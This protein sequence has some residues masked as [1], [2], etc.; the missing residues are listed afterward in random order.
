MR[1]E[2][3]VTDSFNDLLLESWSNMLKIK[4]VWSSTSSL[5]DRKRVARI[6]VSRMSS[7]FRATPR[8]LFIFIF[9]AVFFDIVSGTNGGYIFSCSIWTAVVVVWS[10]LKA[11]GVFP[12]SGCPSH[13]GK[14]VLENL[15]TIALTNPKS[16]GLRSHP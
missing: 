11:L 13:H 6:G 9:V 1:F 14:Q 7:I 4:Y 12:I 16:L 3:D 8:T 10:R 2:P 5:E 15:V